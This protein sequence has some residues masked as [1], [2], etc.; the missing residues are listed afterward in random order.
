MIAMFILLNLQLAKSARQTR[1]SHA[2]KLI[3]ISHLGL[4]ESI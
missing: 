4:F 1:L 3:Q 2:A